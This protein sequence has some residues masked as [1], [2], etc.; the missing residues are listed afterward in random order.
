M[1]PMPRHLLIALAVLFLTAQPIQ[2]LTIVV[3]NDGS[4]TFS[5]GQVLGDDEESEKETKSEEKKES[6]ESSKENEL[7]RERE[8]KQ[9]EQEREQ[10]K[11]TQ[12][13][14]REREKTA[15]EKRVEQNKQL[16]TVKLNEKKQLRVKTEQPE[17]EVLIEKKRSATEDDGEQPEPEH[18][19]EQ[20]KI[21][22]ESFH[23]SFPAQVELED[24]GQPEVEN[25]N[26][27]ENEQDDDRLQQTRQDRS[28]RTDKIEIK[29][30][31]NDDGT[32]ETE[33]EAGAIKAKFKA[34]EFTVDPATNNVL[35][36]TPTGETHTLMH[37]PDQALLQ[38]EQAGLLD[39]AD[40]LAQSELS[41]ETNAD[42]SVM[43]KTKMK[44]TRRVF[45]FIPITVEQEVTLNDS[46]GTTTST[47][48]SDSF[49]QKMLVGLSN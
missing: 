10:T 38:M 6:E 26:E 28:K 25:E 34:A 20:E 5:Q 31:L 44:R 37:L 33:I 11:Q 15:A 29:R 23:L 9:L 48:I 8:K 32:Q 43:Y 30:Q 13:K 47:A 24:D 7:N 14:T 16:K 21:E 46:D 3:A 4:M 49:F 41:L 1:K 18:V 17:T 35:I 42:G 39:S 40:P 22:T 12:E 45:G 36:S 2:A 27:A 19:E